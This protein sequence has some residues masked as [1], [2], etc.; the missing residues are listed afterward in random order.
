M[1]KA[2]LRVPGYWSMRYLCS[3]HLMP[4]SL[5]V[6]VT[7]RCNSK[8]LTCNIWR[9]DKVSEFTAEEFQ[10]TFGSIG[11]TPYWITVSGG[12]P[13]L[14]EDL[15]QIVS[16]MCESMS[17]HVINIPTNG[18]VPAIAEKVSDIARKNPRTQFIVNLSLDG[19]GGRH[20]EIR[21]VRGA[22]DRALRTYN[23]LRGVRCRNLDVSV[24]TVI[25]KYNVKEIP[26]IYAFVRTIKPDSYIT[27]IAEQRV[28]LGTESSDITP[29]YEDYAEA[30]AFLKEKIRAE[31]KEGTPKLINALRSEYY[32]L[33]LKTIKEKRQA[34]PC[35]AGYCSCQIAPDGDVW[36]CCVRAD[37]LGN[38]RDAGYDF[39]KIWFGKKAEETRKSIKN[40]E[41]H[42]PLANASYTNMLCN[43][44]KILSIGLRFL[45]G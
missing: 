39:K 38:L 22:F 1:I 12:E 35:Y 13:F 11:K 44:G 15:T 43:P 21:G 20:D 40:N 16:S 23:E 25:S 36:A 41:C 4:L 32:D 10:K 29:S 3:P 34:I 2:L 30:V 42:C 8:C 18:L 31:K 24:H 6:S 7:Y 14:R 33:A 17:P 27:E 5:T 19:V 45:S 26:K 9:R 37:V 28:E